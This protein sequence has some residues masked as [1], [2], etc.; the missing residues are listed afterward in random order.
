MGRISKWFDTWFGRAVNMAQIWAWIPSGIIA[1][2]SGWAS[3][4]VGWI[5]ALGWAGWFWA[6][7]LAFVTSSLAFALVARTKLWRVEAR[8][9]AKLSSDSS[10][11]D[12]MATVYQDKRLF[13][14]DLAPAGRKFVQGR[15]FINCEI[16][17]PGTAKLFTRSSEDKPWPVMANN[18]MHDV[19]CIE[20]DH[21]LLPQNAVFF[22]DCSFQDCH[23]YSLTLMFDTRSDGVGW[24]WITPD[25]RQLIL[26]DQTDGQQPAE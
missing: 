8:I 3:T 9:R 5:A 19:D 26:T 24:N 1:V 17:G 21:T 12:P 13:L 22:P 23:F 15:K 2:L 7:L 18:L 4:S 16:I 11:F 14:R 6:G 20:V 10:P 25:R